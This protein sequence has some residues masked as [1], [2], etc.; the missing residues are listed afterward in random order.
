MPVAPNINNSFV[1][2]TG[3]DAMCGIEGRC[4]PLLV[5]E[6]SCLRVR[7]AA[8]VGRE[9]CCCHL[10]TQHEQRG[11]QLR[12]R[13][14]KDMAMVQAVSARVPVSKLRMQAVVARIRLLRIPVYMFVSDDRASSLLWN[15]KPESMR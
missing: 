10:L 8:L 12:W 15:C 14:T 5:A 2:S 1:S 13:S 3:D 7:R 4:V 9:R 11:R 6:Y